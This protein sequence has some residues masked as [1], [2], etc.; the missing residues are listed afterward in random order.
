MKYKLPAI[1]SKIG[2]WVY[3]TAS[4][5]FDQI[6]TIVDSMGEEIY[7]SNSLKDALQRSITDNYKKIE[8]YILNQP[9]MFFNSLVLAVYDGQPNWIQVELELEGTSFYEFGFLTLTGEEHVFPIDGQHRVEGIKEAIKTLNLAIRNGEKTDDDL[10]ELLSQ[11]ISV[12]FVGHKKDSNG[13]QRS[14]RL[15]NTLNRYAKPVSPTDIITLDEDDCTAV[16]TRYLIEES[17]LQLFKNDALDISAQK[18]INT[19]NQKA[20]TS[21]IAFSE[22]N[23]VIQRFYFNEYFKNTEAFQEYKEQYFFNKPRVTFTDFKRYRSNQEVLNKFI[24][25]TEEFWFSFEKTLSVIHSYLTSEEHNPAEK[26]RNL[27]NGGNVLFR[28]I[29]IVPFI[30]AILNVYKQNTCKLSIEDILVQCDKKVPF[31]LSSIPWTNTIWLPHNHTINSVKSTFIRDMFI[32]HID[33]QALTETSTSKLKTTYASYIAYEG[34][35]DQCTLD[36]LLNV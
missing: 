25:F 23:E 7:Q 5:T 29:G 32:F 35:L 27:D 19:S 2:N 17:A 15:F 18:Q 6:S 14:R 9:D 33:K 30:D 26:Y 1:K 8:N 22:A 16:T 13:M 20:F 31:D 11:K 10:Q 28:P 34:D 21:L 4:L 24:K 12:N 3:Y 36:D